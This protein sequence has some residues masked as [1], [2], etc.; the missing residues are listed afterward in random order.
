MREAGTHA[1]MSQPRDD[2]E[3]VTVLL[4]DFEVGRERVVFA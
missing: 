3:L 1:G 4:E 2:G